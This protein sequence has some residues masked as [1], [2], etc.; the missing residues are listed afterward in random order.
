MSGE[1]SSEI[2]KLKAI[3]KDGL[4]IIDSL[5][6]DMC[7]NAGAGFVYEDLYFKSINSKFNSLGIILTL[8]D[9]KMFKESM[10]LLRHTFEM[11]LYY[12]LMALGKIYRVTRPHFIIPNGGNTN[13]K[14]RDD[15]FASWMSEWKSGKH[16]DKEVVEINKVKENRIDITYQHEGL[17]DSKDKSKTG[18]VLPWYLWVLKDYDPET[19]FLS[20][21]PS[22]KA[23]DIFPDIT[24][25]LKSKQDSIYHHYIYID[26]IRKNLILNGLITERQADYIL[27]HYNYLSSFLHPSER[28]FD[29]Q[30]YF[31]KYQGGYGD[32]VTWQILLYVCRIQ[33]IF[34]DS[35]LS[36]FRVDNKNARTKDYDAFIAKANGATKYF[37][38]VDNEP[39]KEDVQESDTAKKW[40][41]EESRRK[42]TTVIYYL[43][44]IERLS[45]F[46]LVWLK[47]H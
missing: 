2:E 18:I 35:V 26:S 44:P 24:A 22:V 42:D 28:G 12:R 21:L 25:K 16:D 40:L 13:P 33:L 46:G 19:K 45:K 17:Y 6:E 29:P 30:A 23:G 31:Y 7:Y 39:T 34:L 47:N 9:S 14:A 41:K 20:E 10:I 3:A 8:L 4:K 27:V 36:K 43:D 32:Y 38:F 5:K 15:T 37:W 1:I 11:M